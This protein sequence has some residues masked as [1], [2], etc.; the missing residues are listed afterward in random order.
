LAETEAAVPA[1]LLE[2]RNPMLRTKLA[3]PYVWVAIALLLTLALALAG[4]G[5]HS[6]GSGHGGSWG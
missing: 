5:G 4:C 1:Y 6:G 2:R 3:S